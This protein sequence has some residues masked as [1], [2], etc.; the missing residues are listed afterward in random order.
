[1]AA[2]RWTGAGAAGRHY[3][4][5]TECA[6]ATAMTLGLDANRKAHAANVG[7]ER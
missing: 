2:P 3:A 1:M 4:V 6:G 7:Q 5:P